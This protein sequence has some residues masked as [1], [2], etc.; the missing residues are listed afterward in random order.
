MQLHEFITETLVQIAKGV[1]NAN[2]Q[3]KGTTALVNPQHIDYNTNENIR[4]YGWLSEQEERLR[5]VHLVEFDVAVKETEGKQNK[6]GI[7]VS[8]G[9]I[10]IGTVRKQDTAQESENRIKFGIP[11]VLPNEAEQH[12]S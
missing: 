4:T 2:V 10:G 8:V 5:A 9:A 12:D 6:G 7:G 3:L 1:N 11:M